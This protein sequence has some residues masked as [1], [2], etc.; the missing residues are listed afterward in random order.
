MKAITWRE[1]MQRHFETDYLQKSYLK[2][3]F[4]HYA[5]VPCSHLTAV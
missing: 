5:P 4:Y 3:F 1:D 2:P